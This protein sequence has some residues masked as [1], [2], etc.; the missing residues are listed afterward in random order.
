MQRNV[1]KMYTDTK[2]VEKLK[3]CQNSKFSSASSA[4]KEAPRATS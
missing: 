4:A 2:V 1:Q 3:K